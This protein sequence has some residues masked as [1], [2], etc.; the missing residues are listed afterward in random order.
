MTKYPGKV[1]IT[2]SA[3]RDGFQNI[4]TWIPTEQK[5]QIIEALVACGFKRME[6]T[7][8][9]HPKAIPQMRDADEVA[10]TILAK[11]RGKVRFSALVPNLFGAEKA[12]AKQIDDIEVVV[13]ATDEHNQANTK[14]TIAE[15]MKGIREIN[16]IK[17]QS[18]LCFSVVTAF[19]CP[20]T[21][22]VKPEKV[23]RL[24]GEALE[25][26]ADQIL[27]ADTTGTA[28]PRML[29]ELLTAVLNAYPNIPL[30]LHLHDTKGFG[31]ANVITAMRLG[32]TE[33]DSAAGGLGGCPFTPGAAGNI[34]SE[35]LVTMLDEMGIE[36]GISM[37]ALWE[38][39]D[40]I[41]KVNGAKLHSHMSIIRKNQQ[42]Q[43]Q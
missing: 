43:C 18:N 7:S 40:L 25:L 35:D 22:P 26:G 1:L 8:F 34:A 27:V 6:L 9:V 13:S 15:S 37:P 5:I 21:G 38:A 28:N 10:D 36:T 12:A 14:Q 2:E 19:I 11:Y 41:E 31:L 23:V 29:E 20:F 16:A 30:G 3:A 42:K 39:I 33:I 32:I 4:E 24:L 17:G